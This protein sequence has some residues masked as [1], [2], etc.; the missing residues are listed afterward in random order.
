MSW[1]LA[2]IVEDGICF[3]NV[4]K[5]MTTWAA[6]NEARQKKF[7]AELL[8][9]WYAKA[10]VVRGPTDDQ[11]EGFSVC[12]YH[13]HNL[14]LDTNPQTYMQLFSC[15]ESSA[16]AESESLQDFAKAF[17]YS[18]TASGAGRD[19]AWEVDFKPAF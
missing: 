11:G 4:K 13:V 10:A 12:S 19:C 1:L 8:G 14:P 2:R 9:S 17:G 15:V 3:S 6:E 16:L 5:R 7:A 18:V